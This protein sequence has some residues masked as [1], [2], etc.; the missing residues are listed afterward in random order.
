MVG[1]ERRQI[2]GVHRD[3][4]ARKFSGK[5]GKKHCFFPFFSLTSEKLEKLEKMNFVL[6]FVYNETVQ[7]FRVFLTIIEL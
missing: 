3:E 4:N 1:V 5:I 7:N 6:F 2:S